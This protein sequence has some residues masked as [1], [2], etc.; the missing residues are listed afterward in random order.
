MAV[1][2]GGHGY[3]AVAKTFLNR[4]RKV[5]QCSAVSPLC[6]IDTVAGT[7]V[8]HISIVVQKLLDMI[9]KSNYFTMMFEFKINLYVCDVAIESV[10]TI[11]EVYLCRQAPGRAI[12]GPVVHAFCTGTTEDF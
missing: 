11:F 8:K 10:R 2:P 9:L 4:L 5:A 7:N 6:Q 12:F 1:Q 3:A